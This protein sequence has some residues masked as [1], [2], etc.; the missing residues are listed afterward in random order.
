MGRCAHGSALKSFRTADKT[1]VGF[2]GET[3]V[4]LFRHSPA[5]WLEIGPLSMRSRSSRYV[6]Q[7]S[8]WCVLSPLVVYAAL[9]VA[10]MAQ[11]LAPPSIATDS[12]DY[13]AGDIAYLTGDYWQPGEIV[14][15]QISE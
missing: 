2:G 4:F 13:S 3:H 1:R 14:T 8:R 9:T 6:R 11:T 7:L 10:V 15:L 12:T 5:C